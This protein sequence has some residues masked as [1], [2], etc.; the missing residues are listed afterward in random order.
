M[1]KLVLQHKKKEKLYSVTKESRKFKFQLNI[2]QE[3]KEKTAEATKG[4]K[5]IKKKSKQVYLDD[6]EK[7]WRKKPLHG[8]YPLRIDNADVDRTTTHQWFSRS[9]LKGE[10]EDFILAA[11]D[12]SLA[13]RMYQAKVLKNR[14][15][16][17]CRICTHSE[18]TIDRMIL[19]CPKIVN[20]EYFQRHERVAK[21]MHWTLCKHYEMPHTEKWYEN[22]LQPV[23]EGKM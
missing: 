6:M 23:V 15:D 18:E 7:A 12:Q 11:Q 1:L 17:R 21:F 8:R 16:Q 22:T 14:A 5:E 10:T 9:S 3:E 13:T 2:A 19:G 20:I 4:A